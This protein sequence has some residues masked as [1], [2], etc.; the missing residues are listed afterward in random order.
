MCVCVRACVCACVRACVRACF[1]I[2]LHVASIIK[3]SI[4]YIHAQKDKEE[5]MSSVDSVGVVFQK[6]EA[7]K[8]SAR[9]CRLT[10]R[11]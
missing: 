2:N 7:T 3:L 6:Y 11:S 5:S 10:L 8:V 1:T 4:C 9:W